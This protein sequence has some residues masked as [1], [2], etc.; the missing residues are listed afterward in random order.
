MQNFEK[1]EMTRTQTSLNEVVAIKTKV[2][3]VTEDDAPQAARQPDY[4]AARATIFAGLAGDLARAQLLAE[5]LD[6]QSGALQGQK[7]R[8][9]NK[10]S[11]L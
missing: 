7:C 11:D 10:S 5:D 1:N 9:L 8:R 3:E 2:E 6:A 4:L